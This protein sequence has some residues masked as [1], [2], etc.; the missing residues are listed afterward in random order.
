MM[1]FEDNTWKVWRDLS[2]SSQRFIGKVSDDR[3]V[4]DGY[5]EYSTDGGKT[6]QHDFDIKYTRNI[7]RKHINDSKGHWPSR[8]CQPVS[9]LR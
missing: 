2:D 1:S 5:W 6:W 9:P 4:V 8:H 3:S 7:E